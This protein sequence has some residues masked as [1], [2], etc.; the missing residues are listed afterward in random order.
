LILSL[1]NVPI[2]K[3]FSEKKIEKLSNLI[4][5]E[6]FDD[7]Q[8][9]ITQNENTSNFYI[10][11]SGK[12]DIFVDDKY[13]RTLNENEYFGER[14]LLIQEKRT[15]T[16]IAKG[17]VETYVLEKDNFKK[18]IEGNLKDFLINRI[19]L[20]DDKIELE[21]LMYVKDL[22]SGNFGNVC[23]VQ[24]KKNKMC[25]A[26]KAMNKVQIDHDQL[27]VNIDMEKSIL[28]KIDHPFIMKLVKTLKDDKN[29]YFITEHIKGKELFDVIRDIGL[30]NKKQSLFYAASI[31]IAV[32]Y[33]HKR[34]FI[35][36]DIKPENIMVNEKVLLF[37]T[38]G[39]LKIIDFGTAK[40]ILD[41]TTTIIGTPHY[42]APEVITSEGYTFSVDFW[43]IGV[44]IYEFICGAVPF[45][46]CKEDPMEVY[47]SVINDDISFPNFVK[48][49]MFKNL[50]RNMLKKNVLTRLC[51]LSQIKSH[52]Y[53]ESFDWVNLYLN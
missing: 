29:I 36:R 53:L 40:E 38:K 15:A 20:R 31:M 30:L 47:L 37:Y 26:I 4:K 3:N 41:R 5:I 22:G 17:S 28:L 49:N 32:D 18:I 51:N 45:G 16:A 14:S 35:Y 34:K 43:S 48:D 13:I 50:M 12:I 24:N 52:P 25:Y 7:G 1:S 42:M 19:Y 9:I 33:L 46:E 21:D 2:F 11:K 10:L 6:I 8:K 27:H 44:C 23:L 39:F